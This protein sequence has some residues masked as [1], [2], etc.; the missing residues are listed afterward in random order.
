MTIENIRLPHVQNLG[1]AIRGLGPITLLPHVILG[2]DPI[3]D[4]T[5]QN[6]ETRSHRL[7]QCRL[8]RRAIIHLLG[9]ALQNPVCADTILRGTDNLLLRGL[10]PTPDLGQMTNHDVPRGP[11]LGSRRL[12]LR[13]ESNIIRSVLLAMSFLHFIER[14][15]LEF[16]PVFSTKKRK[17]T[18]GMTLRLLFLLPNCLT[19]IMDLV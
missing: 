12:P 11:S 13:D 8:R 6:A 19:E 1:L 14:V 7:F 18:C 16:R 15:L 17:S 9:P 2:L 4:K 10:A 5:A 3:R